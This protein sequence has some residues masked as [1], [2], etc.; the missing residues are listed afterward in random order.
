VV[1]VGIVGAVGGDSVGGVGEAKVG[2]VGDDGMD[3]VD[4][5]VFGDEGEVGVAGKRLVV[6]EVA[7]LRTKVTAAETYE[8]VEGEEKERVMVDG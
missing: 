5:G 4:V 1:G 6:E 8:V 3:I 7:S 2:G